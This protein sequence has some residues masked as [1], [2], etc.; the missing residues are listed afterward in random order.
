MWLNEKVTIS[1]EDTI[2]LLQKLD[3]TL[4]NLVDE[5]KS[6]GDARPYGSNKVIASQVNQTTFDT[7]VVDSTEL[8]VSLLVGNWWQ[9][10]RTRVIER[11]LQKIRWKYINIE[12]NSSSFIVV[13]DN[14]SM[15]FW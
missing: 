6:Q 13:N 2:E 3:A 10:G 1:T 11:C 8:M 4:L 9:Q 12:A 15:N 7:R 14:M 5:N